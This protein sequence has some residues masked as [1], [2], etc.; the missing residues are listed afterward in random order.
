MQFPSRCKNR[1]D[2]NRSTNYPVSCSAVLGQQWKFSEFR[3]YLSPWY[4][5]SNN[6]NFILKGSNECGEPKIVIS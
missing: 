4:D 6:A 3:G 5:V 2:Q 1:T